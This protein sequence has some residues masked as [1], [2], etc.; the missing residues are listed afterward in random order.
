[1]RPQQLVQAT[2]AL[3]AEQEPVRPVPTS[4]YREAHHHLCRMFAESRSLVVL[5]GE[6][7]CG[8]SYLV[9]HFLAGAQDDVTVVRIKE[10]HDDE[11]SYMGAIIRGIGFDP[12][13]LSLAD[14]ESVFSLFLSHQK[15]HH[16]R[17]ILCLEDIQDCGLW[18]IDIVQRITR[19]E[20]TENHGLMLF[21]AGLPIYEDALNESMLDAVST[22]PSQCICIANFTLAETREY[23]RWRIESSGAAKIVD[24]FEFDAVTLVHELTG[25]DADKV[26]ALGFKC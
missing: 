16:R 1:M 23:L 15:K 20:T 14:L 7:K 21:L 24:V 19:I 3:P 17:T 11:V 13:D 8:T 5:S 9:D 2:S 4:S 12:T 10:L 6:S 18:F 26:S 25:G 22:N